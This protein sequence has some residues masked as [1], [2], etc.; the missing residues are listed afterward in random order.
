MIAQSIYPIESSSRCL[1]QGEAE[2]VAESGWTVLRLLE[3]HGLE[4]AAETGA[5]LR[6]AQRSA[7]LLDARMAAAARNV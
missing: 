1:D 4:H 3:V 7:R 2:R 6:T 5:K